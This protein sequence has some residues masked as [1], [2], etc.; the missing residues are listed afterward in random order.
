MVLGQEIGLMDKPDKHLFVRNKA[1]VLFLL[2]LTAAI[3]H[4]EC[5]FKENEAQ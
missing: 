4:K 5:S 2:V 1:N 3:Y